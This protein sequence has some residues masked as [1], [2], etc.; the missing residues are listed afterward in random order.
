MEAT[1]TAIRVL[2]L[3]SFLAV[4]GLC[5][6][7]WLKRPSGRVWIVPPL[8]WGVFGM[9]LF[10]VALYYDIPPRAMSFWIGALWLHTCFLVLGGVWLYLWPARKK[11]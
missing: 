11:S 5:I 3:V 1:Q 7:A 4:V 2:T 9:I 8:S 6:M 10:A